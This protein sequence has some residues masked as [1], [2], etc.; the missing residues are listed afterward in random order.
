MKA[1]ILA[2]VIFFG[3]IPAH[4]AC[5]F[6]F[7]QPGI[8]NQDT[9]DTV[10]DM[11]L[12]EPGISVTVSMYGC[13]YS[14]PPSGMEWNWFRST[15]WTTAHPLASG[16]LS[17][18][19]TTGAGEFGNGKYGVLQGL[20]I[21]TERNQDR[22]MVVGVGTRPAKPVITVGDCRVDPITNE[23]EAHVTVG[24]A[25]NDPVANAK[26]A[27]NF[28]DN[29]DLFVE[30]ATESDGRL[31]FTLY[32]YPGENKL[33]VTAE[34]RFYSGTVG[35]SNY[36][37]LTSEESEEV[38]LQCP[39]GKK[40]RKCEPGQLKDSDGQTCGP[41]DPE[42]GNNTDSCGSGK[43]SC[44]QP[45][46]VANGFLWH[47]NLDLA[48][49]TR[50]PSTQL[51][52]ERTYTAVTGAPIGDFGPNW[53]HNW[54]T[55][56]EVGLSVVWIDEA[57][58]P[59]TFQF[60]P[61]NSLLATPQ[62]ITHV[63]ERL[64]DRYELRKQDKTKLTFSLEGRL[65]SYTDRFGESVTLTYNSGKLASLSA[66]LAGTI[67]L[68]RN[69][70]GKIA[71][72]TRERDSL[73]YTYTYDSEGRLFRVTDFAGRSYEYSYNESQPGTH[74][75][76]MLS[77]IRDPLGRV[78][79][80]T[81]YNDGRA[82]QQ[83]EPGGGVRTF[84]Y[85]FSSQSA[86]KGK[87]AKTRRR[88]NFIG[89]TRVDEIDGTITTYF[90]DDRFRT[91]KTVF[92]DH[93]FTRFVWNS[94][95]LLNHSSDENGYW[96]SFN[97]DFNGNPVSIQKPGYSQPIS[98]V[99]DQ[100]FNVPIN[101]WAPGQPAITNT[102]DPL[103]GAIT[104][105][106]QSDGA[107]TMALDFTRDSFGN[108]LST[109]NGRGSYADQRN[110]DGLLV[111]SYDAHNPETR[112]YDSRYRLHTQT[113]QSGRVLTY[114]Y[115][116]DDRVISVVDSHGPDIAFTY[117]VMGRIL[118]RS[119]SD[120]TEVNTTSYVWDEHD[121][122]VS[123]TDALGRITR[124]G[125]DKRRILRNPNSIT[126]PAGRVTKFHY[127]RRNRLVKR[128]DP[129]GAETSFQY[130]LKGNLLT[131]IDALGQTTNYQYDPA[132]RK[133]SESRPSV[134]GQSSTTHDIGYEYDDADRLVKET[135]YSKSSGGSNRI[136]YYGYD[137]FGR[138]VSKTLSKGGEVEDHV[139]Y[140]YEAQLDAKL[141]ASSINGVAN[142]GFTNEATPPFS[143][144][145]YSVASVESGNPKGLIEDTFTIA[146]DSTG[147]VS[148]ITG[149]VSGSIFTK[150]YDPLGRLTGF[151]AVGGALKGSLEYD[152]FGR[153]KRVSYSDGTSGEFIYDLLNRVIAINWKEK[154]KDSV[155]QHLTYDLAGNVSHM[156]RE[157]STYDLS[158]DP[159]DQLVKS[160][161]KGLQGVPAYNRE[162]GYD[163]VGNR[164]SDSHS[165]TLS[166][167]VSNF[168]TRNGETNFLAHPDGFGETVQETTGTI[169]KN[170]SY[171]ADGKISGFTSGAVSVGYHYDGLDRL[172]AKT[173]NDGS[174]YTQSFIHLGDE[175]RV[176]LGKA[177][178]GSVT[179]YIDGQ[180]VAERLGEVKNGVGKG[181]ITD[182]LGSVLNSPVA[183]A[184]KSYGLY[185]ELA[186]NPGISLTSSPMLFGFTG[187]MVDAESGLIRTEFRQYDAKLGRWLAQEPEGED[188]P[189]S[190]WYAKN[191]P[192]I[193][194]DPDG[195]SHRNI[196]DHTVGGGGPKGGQGGG[197]GRAGNPF[198]GKNPSEID[199]MFRDKGFEPRGPDPK[200]GKGGYVNPRTGRSY[201]IDFKN[202]FN[203]KPHV[204][205]NRPNTC[206]MPKRK[207]FI[208]D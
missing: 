103:N 172:V 180:G 93:S 190:Y 175:N 152:G 157:H 74:A 105:T 133:V 122:L 89:T 91:I 85:Y 139:T 202:R 156:A 41:E 160:V 14:T 49:A 10:H 98:M 194:I 43:T 29:S 201:H 102:I 62:G 42:D 206:D 20:H 158:Y 35:A 5:Q 187:H 50:T 200:S 22:Q 81:Y 94:S 199:K 188:G 47:K 145:G 34:K 147:N 13:E 51:S 166:E 25:D 57:G 60:Q 181:Y 19:F 17:Y 113:F 134:I 130:D 205:V 40:K 123:E 117:D 111:T 142:L 66:P 54:E 203:E 144:T 90:F 15:A 146:R 109:D 7:S 164:L 137:G 37:R 167:F 76:G 176:L 46:N 151:S 143:I 67:S 195:L 61:G 65:I 56:L 189:N 36:F 112:T 163:G 59:W 27:Y 184:W 23:L 126:D 71:T 95:G 63:L 64:A 107:V 45:V 97:Y 119:V 86:K 80:F 149:T 127:D 28:L 170:Y 154:Y 77:S 196:T 104:R 24:P 4:S 125:Y 84:T 108:L 153:K 132:G 110:A 58:G 2:V 161:F 8:P 150:A 131:V 26:F 106:E 92:S 121:R 6:S 198:R 208:E 169:T 115:D 193:N 136:I 1:F 114:A 116:D 155:R 141:M 159:A 44:G 3:A 96:T 171:R 88:T 75:Q 30:M 12:F 9:W 168:L 135:H 138:M 38:T 18:T 165:N 73:T 177:G 72:V 124:Y 197:T 207:Y 69:E 32:P 39:E 182:H 118:N 79:R 178:D 162:F 87:N 120:G 128:I 53:R 52:L 174:S 70:Q 185:G 82:F 48:L 68:T 204:D 100:V 192:L 148:G 31:D 11:I 55:R 16:S 129:K 183:G 186:V 140:S 21:S 101:I 173:I 33:K 179:T 83:F 191:N 78:S 99:F